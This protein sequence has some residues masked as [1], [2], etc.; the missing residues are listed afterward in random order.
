MSPS[1]MLPESA[2]CSVAIVRMSV[3]FPA[4]FGPRS[5][6]I[7][8]GMLSVTFCSALTPLG[9]VFERSFMRRSMSSVSETNVP[10]WRQSC[11]RRRPAAGMGLGNLIERI[12]HADEVGLDVSGVGEQHRHEKTADD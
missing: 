6:N 8:V 10:R 7:P 1:V 5:P 2:S 12:S 3:D 4:P 11:S 9:Y